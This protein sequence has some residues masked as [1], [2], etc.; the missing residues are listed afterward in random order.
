MTYFQT[1]IATYRKIKKLQKETV[2]N[3][4]D[5]KHILSI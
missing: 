3:Q 1:Q 5:K 2:L 4:I